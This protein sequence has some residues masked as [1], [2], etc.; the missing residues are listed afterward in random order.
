MA[1]TLGGYR[2]A[3]ICLANLPPL[4]QSI[5]LY[6]AFQLESSKVQNVAS[7]REKR[8]ELTKAGQIQGRGKKTDQ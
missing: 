4:K 6:T 1:E 8:P 7:W 5:S 2:N 3:P